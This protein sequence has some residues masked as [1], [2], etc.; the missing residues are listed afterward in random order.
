MTDTMLREQAITG[1]VPMPVSVGSDIEVI[2]G[3]EQL[4]EYIT[5]NKGMIL[6]CLS[7]L[8]APVLGMVRIAVRFVLIPLN[9][10]VTLPL[11]KITQVLRDFS[12]NDTTSTSPVP[13]LTNSSDCAPTPIV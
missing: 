1:E 6:S 12:S 13:M 9:Y 5:Q 2:K 10:V 8:P 3:E 11:T 7:G 4:E